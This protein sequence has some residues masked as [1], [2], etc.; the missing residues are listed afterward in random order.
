MNL[1]AGTKVIFNGYQYL[2][3]TG[4]ILSRTA[5]TAHVE[6]AGGKVV[7]A[8]LSSLTRA[9]VHSWAVTSRVKDGD[10]ITVTSTCTACGATKTTTE[11]T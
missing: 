2:G 4:V 8:R 11:H 9:P 7:A 5:R 10:H 6:L 1:E 3:Q